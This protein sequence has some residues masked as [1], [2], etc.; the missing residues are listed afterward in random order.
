M[1]P[2]ERLIGLGNSKRAFFSLEA[3]LGILM[4]TLALSWVI[5]A[6]MKAGVV[7]DTILQNDV[8]HAH[9]EFIISGLQKAPPAA[10]VDDIREGHW[11]YPN[12]PSIAAV[13]MIP[14]PG[15]SIITQ[16]ATEGTP[17]VTVTVRWLDQNGETKTKIAE[18]TIG[19]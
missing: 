4:L 6:V 8:A 14:L 18:M 10:I 7:H 19:G 16:V 11:N 12:P 9:A 1:R 15:E 5:T 2:I 17:Q 13:G 3:L